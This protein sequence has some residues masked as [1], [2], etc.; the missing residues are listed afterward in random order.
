MRSSFSAICNRAVWHS[1]TVC[2]P[3]VRRLSGWYSDIHAFVHG[4]APGFVC[5]VLAVLA[6]EHH[7][8]KVGQAFHEILTVDEESQTSCVVRLS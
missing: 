6:A 1:R 2:E 4:I 5:F 7:S 3:A 8:E